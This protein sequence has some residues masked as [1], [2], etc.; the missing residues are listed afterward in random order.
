[1]KGKIMK[2]WISIDRSIQNHWLW[3]ERRKLSKFEAWMDILLKANYKDMD[4]KVGKQYVK[5]K[6]G[7]LLTS[8]LKLCEDW[9]WSRD[10]VRKFLNQ[11]QSEN[12]LLVEHT[13][14]YTVLSI[15]NWGLYQN[16]QQ[17]SIQQ[18]K[19]YK[20]LGNNFSKKSTIQ[21]ALDWTKNHFN[22]QQT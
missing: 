10:T 22:I 2:G 6:K 1:M 11:L 17:Q 8:E 15:V 19:T 9:R 16:T 20:K 21:S 4:I 7:S 14:R 5:V 12:M 18:E 13:T 3:K